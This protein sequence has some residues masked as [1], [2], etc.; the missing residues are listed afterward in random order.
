MGV[1]DMSLGYR[2]WFLRFE[3]DL[4]VSELLKHNCDETPMEYTAGDMGSYLFIYFS[5]SYSVLII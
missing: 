5:V 2:P 4:W 1:T 3:H